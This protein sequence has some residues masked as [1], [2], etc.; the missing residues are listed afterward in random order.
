MNVVTRSIRWGVSVHHLPLNSVNINSYMI[1][2]CM[3]NKQCSEKQKGYKLNYIKEML[4]SNLN[5]SFNRCQ[6]KKLIYKRNGII[7]TPSD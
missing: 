6:L 7:I 5:A 4:Y 2:L 1:E 3:Q